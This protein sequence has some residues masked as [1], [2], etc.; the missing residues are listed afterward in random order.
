MSTDT[1]NQAR[2]CLECLRSEVNAAFSHLKAL[3]SE[4]GR[5]SPK[6]LDEQQK[7]SYELAFCVAEIEASMAM[8]N[9]ATETQAEADL[10]QSI[11]FTFCAESIRTVWQRLFNHAHELSTQLRHL[12]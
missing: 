2:Q 10:C 7:V 4:E 11:A 6:L 1:T 8:L 3:C 5:L 12:R 9:Y